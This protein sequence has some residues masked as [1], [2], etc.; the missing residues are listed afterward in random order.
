[1]TSL[2]DEEKWP[3]PAQLGMTPARLRV[4]HEHGWY[5]A[6]VVAWLLTDAAFVSAQLH[7]NQR[8]KDRLA[9][10]YVNHPLEVAHLLMS[11]GV[12]DPTELAAAM[13][14]DTVEDT[15]ATEGQ[16]AW[17]YGP[18][19]TGLVLEV[20]D[21]KS[22]PKARR[23]ELQIEHAAH[24][25]AGGKRLKLADKTVNV[26]DVVYSPPVAWSLPQR[27]Q[28]LEWSAEVVHGLRGTHARRH[29]ST[30][31]CETGADC[32][33]RIRRSGR[34]TAEIKAGKLPEETTHPARKSND[35]SCTGGCR[36]S[37]ATQVGKRTTH[38]QRTGVSE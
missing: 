32:F 16:L 27:I 12:T 30:S 6:G 22:L 9:S 11:A 10:P 3:W 15:G 24:L 31:W 29:S 26:R 23:K 1:M 17:R 28:Y 20:S 18:A 7:R 2:L 4:A 13:L 21:D 33:N 38:C 35:Q 19:V 25:S 8:R 36:D 14:H 34:Q 37:A 5:D